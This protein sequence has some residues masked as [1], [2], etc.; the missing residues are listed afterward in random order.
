MAVPCGR[1]EPVDVVGVWGKSTEST[2]HHTSTHG[3][4][5]PVDAIFTLTV[6]L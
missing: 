1:V 6:A 3:N 4:E 5:T 2:L